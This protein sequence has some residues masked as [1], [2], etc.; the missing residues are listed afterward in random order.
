V[1]KDEYT[2]V[3]CPVCGMM[4][5]EE[6]WSSIISHRLSAV[7]CNFTYLPVIRAAITG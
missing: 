7:S 4:T 1:N 6:S 5:T 2:S 3:C